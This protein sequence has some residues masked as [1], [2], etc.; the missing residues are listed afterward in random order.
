MSATVQLAIV[1][2]MHR[3]GTSAIARGLAALGFDLGPRHEVLAPLLDPADGPAARERGERDQDVLGVELAAHAEAA[4]HVHLGEAQG[5]RRQAEDRREDAAIDVDALGGAEQ[6]QLAAA[7]A[8]GTATQAARLQG[9]RGLAR[10]RRSVREAPARRRPARRRR[11][12]RACGSRRRCSS[13]CPRRA[14]ARRARGPRRSTPATGSGRVVHRDRLERVLGEIAACPTPPLPPA[15]RRSAPRRGRWR[16]GGS[17]ASRRA[18]G[19]RLGM[20]AAAGTS[21]AVSTARTPGSASARRASR[22][23]MRACA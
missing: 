4:A 20:M 12:P 16:A 23:T 6:V 2:G 14:G 10:M 9:R 8:G 15:R 13:R 7:R 5:A 17:A 18:P 19:T 3:A 21:A 1:A 11:R 22:R